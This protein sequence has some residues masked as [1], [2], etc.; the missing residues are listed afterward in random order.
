MVDSSIRSLSRLA[1]TN[2]DQ[3]IEIIETGVKEGA[4]LGSGV[5][6]IMLPNVVVWGGGNSFVVQCYVSGR[7]NSRFYMGHLAMKT[8]F[9]ANIGC[10]ITKKCHM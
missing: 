5:K 3:R 7:H 8:K 1:I 9:N 2:Q 4:A 10:F 6:D